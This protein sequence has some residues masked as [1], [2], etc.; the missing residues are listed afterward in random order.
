MTLKSNKNSVTN[1]KAGNSKYEYIVWNRT[2][3]GKG[4]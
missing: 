3:E 4:N 1:D 2:V